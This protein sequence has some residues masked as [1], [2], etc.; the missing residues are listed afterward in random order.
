V[1]DS[2][3]KK[4]QRTC[5][6]FM[7]NLNV[8]YHE[9]AL[10]ENEKRFYK[11]SGRVDEESVSLEDEGTTRIRAFTAIAEDEPSVGKADARS[12]QWVNITMKKIH[13]LLSMTDGDER[14]H[15]V[16]GNKNKALRG[17]GRRKEK[18][19]KEVVF[20][21]ADESSYELALMFTSDSKADCNIQEPLPALPKL[22]RVEPSGTSNSLISLSDLTSNMVELTLNNTSKKTSPFT[23]K[24][25][26]TLIEE[27]K[28]IKD[29]IKIPSLTSSSGS[30]ASCSKPLKQKVWSIA[31][32][33]VDCPK[34]LRNNR[35]QRI[36]N[37]QST[38]PTE[39]WGLNNIYTDIQ[40][41]LVLAVFGDDSSGDTEGYGSVN[42]NGT[43]F[44][45][46]DEVFLIDPRRRD[47]Y[48]ID[49]SSLNKKSNACFFAKASPS[50]N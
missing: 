21:K 10:L 50:V 46:N 19:S 37:K 40:K 29:H 30:Q 5:N 33:I 17:K 47:V 18:N 20:T 25:L 14:K 38:E 35:K 9:R 2:D 13:R 26:L 8:E 22:I 36:A 48:V 39:K 31:H 49:M 16:S 1:S 12:A 44:N 7:V 41:S 3:V 45:Q 11:R 28:G 24:L 15:Q 23:E 4:D 34:N 6:K 27:V 32:K 43:I 42:C